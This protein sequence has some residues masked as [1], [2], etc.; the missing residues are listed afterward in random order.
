MGY[1]ILMGRAEEETHRRVGEELDRIIREIEA[2]HGRVFSF[3]GDGL[4]AEF[5]SAVEALKCALRIHADAGKRNEN[6][7]PDD[8]I[9]FRIGLSVGEIVVQVDR[10][11]GNTVN[12][13]ARLE[14][15]AE[16]GG[17]AMTETVWQ[18]VRNVV[19]AGYTYFG[20]Q[21]LK[22]IR[23]AVPV[24]TI[25]AS[26]C[27]AW[28]G[29]PALPRQTD[30]GG[31]NAPLDYRASLAIL[32]FRTLQ[33]DQADAYFTEGIIDDIV[34]GLGAIKD[35]VVMSRS[36]TQTFA[37]APLDLRRVG[38]ELDV[39]YVLHGSVRSASGKLRIAV[40]LAEAHTGSVIWIERF[41][42]GLEDLFLLQDQIAIRVATSVAP[43]LRE[44]ELARALRKHPDSMTAYDLVLQAAD[45]FHRA[46]RGR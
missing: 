9:L 8:R 3:G 15:I 33:K 25:P 1:S 6:V 34:F 26:E 32:P 4:M 13:A 30:T 18:Q 35:L 11:G 45:L 14:A 17:I 40:E 29:I 39:R 36:S 23:D 42:G 12:I 27:S 19:A 7:S 44:R 21:R 46:N 31:G 41:D 16:A 24:Y 10:A 22:N 37:G 2:H 28:L 38:H 43:H 5:P 20:E